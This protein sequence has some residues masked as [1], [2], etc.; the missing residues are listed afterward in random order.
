MSR[1]QAS[2][3]IQQAAEKIEI[4]RQTLARWEHDEGQVKTIYLKELALLYGV[5]F[6][7]LSGG[8]IPPDG[9][10]EQDKHELLCNR[11]NLRPISYLPQVA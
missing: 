6:S 4:H 11:A 10:G 3:E 5:P 8:T 2:L 9:G 7:W 1:E